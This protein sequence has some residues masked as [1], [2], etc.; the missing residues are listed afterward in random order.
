MTR[1]VWDLIK[2]SKRFYVR[3]Y[4]RAGSVLFASMIL[5]VCLGLA[6]YYIYYN[7]PGHD[8]YATYGEVPPIPLTPMNEPNYSSVPLLST[9]SNQD[10]D[11]RVIPQ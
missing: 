3:S 5:N 7:L 11:V 6:I 8:F 4:R 1:R 10:S 2:H 9:D